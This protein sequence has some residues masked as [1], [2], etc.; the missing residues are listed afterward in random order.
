MYICIRRYLKKEC[1]KISVP[2]ISVI[3]RVIQEIAN[4]IG[5]EASRKI[6]G[7]QVKLDSA[8]FRKME[9]IESASS[10]IMETLG[11]VAVAT[12]KDI[13]V[14]AE[15]YGREKTSCSIWRKM[16]HKKLGFEQLSDI[17]AFRILVKTVQECYAV[18][19]AIHARK[20][21]TYILTFNI[22][23]T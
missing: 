21:Y 9:A 16:E 10:P 12:I 4:Y 3:S 20:E 1:E 13:N 19:G 11:G 5:D 6:P 15:I 7:K 18:L 17:I 23:C 14:K 8:Y 2:C 22:A